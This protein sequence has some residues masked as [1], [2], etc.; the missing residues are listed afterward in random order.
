[1]STLLGIHPAWVEWYDEHPDAGAVIPWAPGKHKPETNDVWDW[2][3]ALFMTVRGYG[4]EIRRTEAMW[5]LTTEKHTG[6]EV[7]EEFWRYELPPEM[8]EREPDNVPVY[9]MPGPGLV[10]LDP[11]R[12]DAPRYF[13]LSARA[14]AQNGA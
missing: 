3:V 4:G 14:V 1:M 10:E 8:I 5:I 6:Q 9:V 2:Q 11:L 13:R 7:W 12:P